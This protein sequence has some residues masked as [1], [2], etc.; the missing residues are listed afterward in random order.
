MPGFIF[1]LIAILLVSKLTAEPDR[2]ILKT[3]DKVSESKI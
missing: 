1:A 3:F 2:D